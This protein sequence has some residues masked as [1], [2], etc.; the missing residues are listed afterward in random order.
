MK[1]AIIY[2]VVVFM[3]LLACKA[4]K[5]EHETICGIFYKL[6]KGKDFNTS[7]TVE[8]KSDSTFFLVVGTAAGKP[9]CT[10]KWKIVDNEFILLECGEITDVTEALSSGYMSQREH[11]LQIISKN[12]IKY[13]DVVLKRKKQ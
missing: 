8:L 7:Y 4:Q 6:E 9:Q 2:I 5:I 1:K 10:G 12:K 11:K 3:S 13:K